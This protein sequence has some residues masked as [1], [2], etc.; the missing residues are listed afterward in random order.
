MF[1]SH[2]SLVFPSSSAWCTVPSHP[3]MITHVNN[4]IVFFKINLVFNWRIIPY[5][6]LLVSAKHQHASAIGIHMSPPSWTSLPSLSPSHLSRLLQSPCLSSLSHTAV[7]LPVIPVPLA[8][9]FTYG[10]ATLHVT[11]S[12]HLTLSFLPSPHHVHK[13]VFYVCVSTAALW[14]ILSV[15]SF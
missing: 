4:S 13:S 11:S 5:R 12:I 10:N 9:C 2:L 8:I 7:S 15:P 6:I 3:P 14:V 1:A